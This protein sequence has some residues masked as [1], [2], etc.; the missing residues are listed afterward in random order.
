M[1]PTK[2]CFSLAAV[3]FALVT[4]CSSAPPAT[5]EGIAPSP[6]ESS[7]PDLYIPPVCTT[8]PGTYCSLDIGYQIK[9]SSYRV[10]PTIT[11]PNGGSWTPGDPAAGI[12]ATST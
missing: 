2:T 3:A 12:W 4:G 11:L 8:L 5:E 1:S 10:C 6:N 9:V 7:H